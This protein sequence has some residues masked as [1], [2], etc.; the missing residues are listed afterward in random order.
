MATTEPEE[1]TGFRVL[2]ID[3]F[4]D[5]TEFTAASGAADLIVVHGRRC[6]RTEMPLNYVLEMAAHEPVEEEP[7][8]E[9]PRYFRSPFIDQRVIRRPRINKKINP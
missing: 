8:H 4:I 1:R 3:E 9:Y 7:R 5:I 2:I 6:G